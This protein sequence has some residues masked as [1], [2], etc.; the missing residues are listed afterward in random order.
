MTTVE[1]DEVAMRPPPFEAAPVDPR[2]AIR[3]HGKFFF[4][5]EHKHFIRGVTYGPSRK[6]ITARNFP[7]PRWS[8]RISR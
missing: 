4:A 5:G 8:T 7:N 1:I 3:V 2:G 6:V